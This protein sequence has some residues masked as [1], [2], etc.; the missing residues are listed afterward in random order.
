MNKFL[1]VLLAFMLISIAVVAEE[2]PDQDQREETSDSWWLQEP[3]VSWGFSGNFVSQISRENTTDTHRNAAAPNETAQSERFGLRANTFVVSPW[4]EM[5]WNRVNSKVEMTYDAF[6]DDED[7]WSEVKITSIWNNLFGFEVMS[8]AQ[9]DNKG[10]GVAPAGTP[11]LNNFDHAITFTLNRLEEQGIKVWTEYAANTVLDFFNL[12]SAGTA[13]RNLFDGYR[14]LGLE[15]DTD[16]FAAELVF[17]RPATQF[18]T[19]WVEA[20]DMFDMWTMLVNDSEAMELRIDDLDSDVTIGREAY[21][22]G[23]DNNLLANVSDPDFEGVANRVNVLHTI[24]PIEGLQLKVATVVPSVDLTFN[25]WLNGDLSFA[26]EQVA[27]M[28]IGA[29][30]AVEGIGVLGV[31]GLVQADY[32]VVDSASGPVTLALHVAEPGVIWK[33]AFW[34]DANLGEVMGEGIDLFVSVDGRHGTY[35]QSAESQTSDAGLEVHTIGRVTKLHLGTEFGMDINEELRLSAAARYSIGLGYNYESVTGLSWAGDPAVNPA[36]AFQADSYTQGSWTNANR[37]GI[38]PLEVDLRAD[39][40]LSETL[41]IWF[42]N[43]FHLNN[44]DF[45]KVDKN[46]DRVYDWVNDIDGDTRDVFG[47]ASTNSLELGLEAVASARS[48][49]KLSAGYNL[50]LGL[51]VATNLT[52]EGVANT[53]AIASSYAAWKSQHFTPWN[54]S[55]EWVYSY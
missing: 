34:I 49:V 45:Q 37:Y 42:Q 48:S 47:Y 1:C 17:D 28:S 53:A 13:I 50:Y 31:G 40:A 51:P 3:A 32:S 38:T 41:G 39:M 33:P 18:D 25:D 12:T 36:G 22:I 46:G 2:V 16:R 54:L 7:D 27:N 15:V 55:A 11:A 20:R 21:G 24:T 10:E 23:G 8:A 5:D 14:Q 35:E 9:W 6:R 43:N 29:D 26:G 44:V 52:G 30:Y 4:V 19:A